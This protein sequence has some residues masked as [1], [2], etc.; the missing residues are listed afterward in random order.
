ML[1]TTPNKYKSK[2]TLFLH[3]QF[4]MIFRRMLHSKDLHHDFIVENII[5]DQK[6]CKCWAEKST[7]IIFFR[8]GRV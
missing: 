7:L 6:V 2:N 4:V 5:G 8:N 3:C 1:V